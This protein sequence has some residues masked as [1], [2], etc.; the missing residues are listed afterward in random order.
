MRVDSDLEERGERNIRRR[1]SGA[2]TLCSWLQESWFS[3]PWFVLTRSPCRR[4]LQFY[5]TFPLMSSCVSSSRSSEDGADVVL[6]LLDLICSWRR[7]TLKKLANKRARIF[8]M[9]ISADK[10]T[11]H[12]CNAECL[13]A[14]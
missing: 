7:W 4:R 12:A 1:L 8:S 9:V 11:K 5:S 14:K 6:V 3:C 10:K 2:L 13:G